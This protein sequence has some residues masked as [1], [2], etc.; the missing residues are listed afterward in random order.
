MKFSRIT[1]GAITVVTATALV[2][3]VPTT[4]SAVKVHTKKAKATSGSPGNSGHCGGV[5]HGGDDGGSACFKKKG[6]RFW[7]KDEANDGLHRNYE[8]R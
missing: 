4:A 7:V 3:L 1:G 2:L 8:E 6:D 5:V